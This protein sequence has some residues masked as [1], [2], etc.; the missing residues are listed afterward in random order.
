M[1][2]SVLDQGL[3]GTSEDLFF[4]NAVVTQATGP[5]LEETHYYPYGL[6]MAG[7][8]SNVL[9]GSNYPETA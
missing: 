4:D 6:T 3:N 7:I 9:K 8:S 2:S 5:V 1:K